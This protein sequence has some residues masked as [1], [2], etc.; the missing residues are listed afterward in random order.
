MRWVWSIVIGWSKG[1]GATVTGRQV[2]NLR[3]SALAG[4]VMRDSGS[5]AGTDRDPSALRPRPSERGTSGRTH[6]QTPTHEAAVPTLS[7]HISAHFRDL[8][9]RDQF[10]AA[11]EQV[12]E[13]V[14]IT[15]LDARIT[16]GNPACER[17]T[18][19]SHDEVIGQ[20][21]RLL[22][23][24][25]QTPWF[26]DAMW[27][28]LSNG[29]PWSADLVNR[30]K[31]GS[32]FTEEVVISPIR[33]SSGTVTSYVAVKRD[34]TNE[35]N[36]EKRST[37]LARQRPLITET[38]RGLGAADTPE[39]TAQAICRQ[40]VHFEGVKAA[41]ISLFELDGATS[42]LGFVAGGPPPPSPEKLPSERSR[43]LRDRATDGPWI[44]QWVKRPGH[45][46][47]Q[48]LSHLRVRSVAYAPIRNDHRLIGLLVIYAEGSWQEVA[49]A[50]VLPALVEFA[51]LTGA[52]VGR[53]VAAR[54]EVG[55]GRDHLSRI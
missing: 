36:I 10:A 48:L 37:E 24:G 29:L 49:V 14:M 23:S 34:V 42:L 53:D 20:N 25:L 21:P 2:R 12:A 17:V 1:G 28:A 26:Y 9:D 50:E 44:E 47:N 11:I 41:Y 39:A 3:K 55:R 45:P 51:D 31:D 27:A 43:Q 33:D 4:G 32:L 13:S 8:A 19:Y 38:I 15:D 22:K 40:V 5:E 7:G 52:L 16:Y 35:R 30:R 6:K 46:Y 18:G 54:T